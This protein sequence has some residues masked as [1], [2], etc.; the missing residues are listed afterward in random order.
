[1]S[2]KEKLDVIRDFMSSQFEG[3][4]IESREEP[5]RY[6]YELFKDNGR[7]LILVLK[8]FLDAFDPQEIEMQLMNYNL[9]IVARSLG[10]LPILVTTSGCIFDRDAA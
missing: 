6:R 5:D 9:A 1:M 3:F 7:H 8:E 10:D 4:A 2:N